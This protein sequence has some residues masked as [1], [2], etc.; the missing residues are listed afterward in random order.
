MVDTVDTRIQLIVDPIKDRLDQ[1]IE[2]LRNLVSESGI[3]VESGLLEHAIV[4][5][6]K[7]L[8]PALTLLSAEF[9]PCPPDKPVTMA[10]AVEL[11]HIASLMHD[12][13]VD[14]S[15]MRRGRATVSSLWGGKIAVLL[16]DYVFAT[17]AT[18]V[19]DTGNIRVI[20]RFSEAIMELAKGQLSEH[21]ATYNWDQSV[22]DYEERI[23]YK[24]ASLFSTAAECGS[25]LSGLEESLCQS[26][27]SYGYYLGMAFQITD[28]MLDF[29]GT[30]QE[31]GKP[32]GGDLL[33][34]TLTLPS[35]R[36]AEMYPDNPIMKRLKSGGTDPKDLQDLVEMI[37]NSKAIG[38]TQ[39]AVEWYQHQ[40]LDA[41]VDLAKN[42][43]RRALEMLAE[44]V[45]SRR[46]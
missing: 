28:D 45:T 43:S 17:S 39:K 46:T 20:R 30:E 44:Y 18:Y 14:D 23:Y 15:S 35:L 13:T 1:V 32:V 25:V 27:K 41:L 22:A 37:R 12:D 24:T 33:Q 8:R 5:G 3:E 10:T 42:D 38:E 19:C 29:L 7:K 9:H 36:F 31:L 4:S 40:S 11:L 16:G 26:L 21:F 34:G 2:S 6:G